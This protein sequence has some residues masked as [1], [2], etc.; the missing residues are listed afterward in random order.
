MGPKRRFFGDFLSADG[1]KVTLRSFLEQ[2]RMKHENPSVSLAADTLPTVVPAAFSASSLRQK[3]G[4]ASKAPRF[5]CRWQRFGA[6]RSAAY[7][8]KRQGLLLLSRFP[9]RLSSF[10][11]RDDRVVFFIQKAKAP[12]GEGALGADGIYTMMFI[13]RASWRS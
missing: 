11:P 3:R 4:T 9:Y 8:C 10:E 6:F 5:I 1:K 2:G 7:P 12:S 13:F